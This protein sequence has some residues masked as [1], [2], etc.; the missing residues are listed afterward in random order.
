MLLNQLVEEFYPMLEKRNLKLKINKPDTLMYK[1]DADKLARALANLLKN[2]ISYS[3]ENTTIIIE[4][5]KNKNDVKIIFKNK[6]DNIPE[7]KLEKLFD[8][9]YRG[10]ESRQSNNGGTGLG[11][12]ITKEIIELHNWTIKATSNDETITFEIN[13]KK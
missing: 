9:F 8:K 1:A 11:L 2:A 3:Y 10:D 13:L 7:Y 5:V 4:M 12:T 6:G